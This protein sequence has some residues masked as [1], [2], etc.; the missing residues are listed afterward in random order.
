MSIKRKDNKGRILR[1]GEIQKADGRYEY[2]YNDVKGVRRSLYSWR[3]TKSDPVPEGKRQCEDLRS[4]EK[5]VTKDV[6]DGI[7]SKSKATLNS[8]W[9]IYISN[10]PE[11]RE[12]TRDTYY[13]MYR[14]YI[15]D[16]LGG[17]KIA[18][19]SYSVMKAFFNRLIFDLGLKSNSVRSI[20]TILHP[21]FKVAV[22]DGLIRTNPLEGILKELNL[23]NPKKHGLTEKQQIAFLNYLDENYIFRHWKPLFVCLLGTGCRA[24][25]ML[26]L[27]WSDILWEENLISI[28]HALSYK[29]ERKDTLTK[30]ESGVRVIP[31]FQSVRLALLEEKIRHPGSEYVFV[32]RSGKPRVPYDI[33]KAIDRILEHYKLE[34]R[35]PEIPNFT[36]HQLRHT[37]CMRLCERETDLKLIQEIMGH[38]KIS[39]TMDIYNESTVDRKKAS[40]ERIESTTDFTTS[41]RRVM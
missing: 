29:N 18:S 9:E 1:D 25:E 14:K 41:S 5:A 39:T 15:Q 26:G 3:L 24:S 33:N 28:T 37:F 17:M 13:Y 34:G 10:K 30:T 21:V 16:E 7:D 6:L 8:R 38:A 2:R 36:A 31:M 12:T 11:L 20:Y 27:K 35:T 19:I 4:L 22:R 32:N 23:D 40:F